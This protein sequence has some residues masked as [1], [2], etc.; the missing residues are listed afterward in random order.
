MFPGTWTTMIIPR[1][2][3]F[4]EAT[5]SGVAAQC[6]GAVVGV[7]PDGLLGNVKVELS[8]VCQGKISGVLYNYR[9]INILGDMKCV[10][11]FSVKYGQICIEMIEIDMEL[12]LSR[13]Q[14]T[15]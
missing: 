3:F 8:E 4:L 9:Y 14:T 1:N 10:A 6:F 12:E 13:E 15:H 7:I 11:F 5:F 2:L